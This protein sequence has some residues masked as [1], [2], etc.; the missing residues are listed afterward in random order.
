MAL[1]GYAVADPDYEIFDQ[2]RTGLSIEQFQRL[3]AIQ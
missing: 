2:L 3:L 1:R